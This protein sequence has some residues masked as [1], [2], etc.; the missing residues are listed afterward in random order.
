MKPAITGTGAILVLGLVLFF[1]GCKKENEEKIRIEGFLATDALGNTIAAIGD[2][3]DDW[4]IRAW[5]ELTSEEQNLLSFS[6]NVSLANTAVSTIHTPVAYPS[7]VSNVSSIA[8]RADDSVKVKVVLVDAK[9]NVY[10]TGAIKV[11]SGGTL[12]FDVS[13]PSKYPAGLALRYYYS[14]SA[15]GQLNFKAGYGDIMICKE[16][17]SQYQ[18]CF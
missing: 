1:S 3:G 10:H 12:M 11:K 13:D 2:P 7:P 18:L 9:L 4:K 6:D 14:F 16:P 8:F 5:S 15:T 17:V